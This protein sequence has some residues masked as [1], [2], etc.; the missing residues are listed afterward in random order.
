MTAEARKAAGDRP[1]EVYEE[2]RDL[3]VRGG[4]APGSRIVET[5]IAERLEVS[6]TPVR[7]ALQRLEQEGYILS[8]GQGRSRARV[9][10]L[11]RED[12][13]ELFYIIGQVEGLAARWAAELPSDERPELA[14]ALRE[15]NAGMGQEAEAPRADR[16]LVFDL[17]RRFHRAYVEAGAGPRLLALHDAIKPQGERYARVYVNF[18][19]E[20]IATSVAEHEIIVSAIEEGRAAEAQASVETNWRNAAARLARVID[21]LGERGSW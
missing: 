13:R 6:R 4:L 21:W 11:T 20:E 10:P 7:A 5:D 2:L 14:A 17:D 15:L 9:A 8:S 12:S 3:I 16:D 1:T 19:L 18:L